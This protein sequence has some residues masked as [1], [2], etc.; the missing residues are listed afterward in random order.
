MA[1]EGVVS[2]YSSV[3]D[4]AVPVP[5]SGSGIDGRVGEPLG[6]CRRVGGSAVRSTTTVVSS[7]LIVNRPC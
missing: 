1:V 4:Q 3:I 2:A 7:V 5:R 6:E